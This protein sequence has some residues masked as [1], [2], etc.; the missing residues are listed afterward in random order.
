MIIP[1]GIVLDL[2]LIV[3]LVVILLVEFL[4]PIVVVG[5]DFMKL[6]LNVYVGMDNLMM[7]ANV[8]VVN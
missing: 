7:E 1:V 3:H 4:I 2:H 6:D 5:E 8:L